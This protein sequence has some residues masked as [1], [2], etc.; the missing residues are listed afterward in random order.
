MVFSLF[1]MLQTTFFCKDKD[2]TPTYQ[3]LNGFIVS[4]EYFEF[5][6]IRL[7]LDPDYAFQYMWFL[8]T[9]LPLSQGFKP[10]IQFT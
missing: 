9:K 5:L 10:G 4:F 7:S 8:G 3:R 2:C 1:C 6:G